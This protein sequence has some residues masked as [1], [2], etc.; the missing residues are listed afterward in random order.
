VEIK[1]PDSH[2][3]FLT[4]FQEDYIAQLEKKK[5]IADMEDLQDI[6]WLMKNEAG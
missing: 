5:G 2:A 3:D 1:I 6:H 4:P